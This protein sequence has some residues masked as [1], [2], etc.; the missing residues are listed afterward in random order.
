MLNFIQ[1]CLIFLSFFG[2]FASKICAENNENYPPF[3][4]V[5]NKH[6]FINGDLKINWFESSE[7][8]RS[9]G[10]NLANI[11]S[12]DEYLALEKYILARG[13]GS[14]LWFDGNDLANEGRYMSHST[15][16]PIVFTK[17]YPNNPDNSGDEDCLEVCIHGKTLLMNDNKCARLYYAICQLREPIMHCCGKYSLVHQD[18]NCI[19]KNLVESLMQAADAFKSHSQPL[20]CP[21]S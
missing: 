6:Y 20:L 9:I 13:I 11:A 5:G 12:L 15:G 17:W 8:C 18:E 1:I 16:Q 2:I 19:L 3:E 4:K 21:T 14:P 7:Y 10:G